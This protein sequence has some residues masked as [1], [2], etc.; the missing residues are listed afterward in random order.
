[1]VREGLCENILQA[2]HLKLPSDFFVMIALAFTLGLLETPSDLF[3]L[4]PIGTAGWC[5]CIGYGS[6]DFAAGVAWT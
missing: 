4:A 1:M 6:S 5:L 3:G 2:L